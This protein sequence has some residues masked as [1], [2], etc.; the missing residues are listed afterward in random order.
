MESIV[1]KNRWRRLIIKNPKGSLPLIEQA[2]EDRWMFQ[3]RINRDP[4]KNIPKELIWATSDNRATVHYVEDELV[5]F[6]YIVVKGDG[7]KEVAS[8]ISRSID[9]FSEDEL[10]E[11][12]EKAGSREEKTLAIARLGVGAPDEFDPRFFQLLEKALSDPDP[13]VRRTVVWVNGY[14]GWPQFRQLL[15]K[16][17]KADP[18]ERVREEAG[19]VVA[20]YESEG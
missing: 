1:M 20:G 12:V 9:V 19:F 3:G 17:A 5:K 4:K 15:E 11:M 13:E 7:W 6:P 8:S 14:T 16:M 18:D 2:D 10:V